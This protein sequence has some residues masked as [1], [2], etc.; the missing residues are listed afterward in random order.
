MDDELAALAEAHGVA[1]HYEDAEQRRAD[2]DRDVVVAV[3]A[4]LGVD[5]STPEAV[6]RALTAP[7]PEPATVVLT[8]G[9]TLDGPGELALEDGRVLPLPAAPPPG[10]HRL[11][12]RTVIVAPARLA[13]PTRSWGW[14]LQLY[15]MRSD[16]SWG[17]GDYAD[18]ATIARRSAAELGAGVLLVNPVQAVAPTTPVERSPYSP[19]SRR[20]ANPL[21]LR[22]E[23]TDEYRSA[24]P[25]TRRAVDALRPDNDTEL[26]DY[27]AVWQAKKAALE[28]LRPAGGGAEP[29][30]EL[31]D[32]ARFCALAEEH[33]PDWRE[34]PEAQ[35]DP[36]TATADPDRVAFHAWLQE[37]CE[38]Q[39]SR[40]RDA[41]RDMPVGIVHDLPV[42]VH[43]GGAD[44]WAVRD[45]FAPDV[46]VGAP[47][48]AFSRLGQ[49][50][51]LPPWRPDKL[52]EQGYEPL[53]AVIRNVLKH[54]DGIRVD[55]VAGLWRL[56]WIPPGEPAARGTYVR[57]DE[58]AMLAVLTLEADRAGAVVV[59]ED[60][61]TVEPVVTERLHE[62]GML[63]SAVLW[64]QRDYRVPGHPLVPPAD[65]T[66]SAMASISTHDLPTV[67]GFLTAEHVRVRAEL[68]QFASGP[69]GEYDAAER[70]RRE[71]V[72]LLD[73][74]GVP[75]DDLVTA[76]H[77]LLAKAPSL[78]LL[79]SPQDALGETRQP[80]LPGT[81]DQYPNWR[82]P[83]PVRLPALFA[84]ERVRRI[85]TAL[86]GGRGR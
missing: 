52:A 19:S 71:L 35:R 54:A 49:D 57:Y 15:A 82:I 42:G 43:P 62:H 6:R 75:A 86:A 11:G 26:I 78:L 55:H 25:A 39:L 51:G 84:D 13:P 16:E 66:V 46:R 8:A 67:A 20:F 61:G 70:E 18:L 3:L 74:E 22:V 2:V 14:M 76:F 58:D 56:W 69:D 50:W 12:D 73:K 53:R 1:T 37:L 45:A 5:A 24:D 79:T 32:F 77:V 17:M 72:G 80:N 10:Y 33:G 47:P 59:G 63:S 30:G 65:W 34:W 64:F 40:A 28:L 7:R 60:L 27:D 31:R 21:Y 29:V 36:A 81:V 44:T 48:D 4:Q 23:D 41:A 68:G 38:Q 85:A 9:D 83:L